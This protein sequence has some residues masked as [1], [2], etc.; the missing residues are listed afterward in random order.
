MLT[1]CRLT[2]T[3]K[4]T[5]TRIRRAA[6]LLGGRAHV[7]AGDRLAPNARKGVMKA[8]PGLPVC[9]PWGGGSL[10]AAM[11]LT[12]VEGEPLLLSAAGA[13]DGFGG[14]EVFPGSGSIGGSFAAVG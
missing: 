2:P 9:R 12:A 8:R 13:G 10:T 7:G 3:T 4:L 6:L 11:D 14:S 1:R 5:V